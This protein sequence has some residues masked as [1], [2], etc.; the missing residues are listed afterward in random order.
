MF[1][2]GSA[3]RYLLVGERYISDPV[4][5]FITEIAFTP[6]PNKSLHAQ[7]PYQL[8]EPTKDISEIKFA[9]TCQEGRQAFASARIAYFE[10]ES[11]TFLEAAL[12]D[13]GATVSA[14][15]GWR[16]AP[17]SESD[18][19]NVRFGLRFQTPHTIEAALGECFKL[20]SFLSLISHQCVYPSNFHVRGTG[21]NEFYELHAKSARRGTEREHTWSGHTLVLPDED[22]AKF[23]EAL[24]NW[25]RD[26]DKL[27]RSRYLYRYSLEEPYIFST[28][29][30][31]CIFQAIEGIVRLS[32]GAFLP[33]DDLAKV[34]AAIRQALPGHAKLD[35]IVRKIRSN[36]TE[37]PA[38]L[39]K[40][41]LPKLFERAHVSAKFM[42]GEFVD[43]IYKRRNK[44]SH[45]GSHLPATPFDDTLVADT[46]LLTAIYLIL[47]SLR[48]GLNPNVA[49]VM[50]RDSFRVELPLE[51]QP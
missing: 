5:A 51:V 50:F 13:L 10:R 31:L 1:S 3:L 49:L 8:I 21:E 43:R 17:P 30:F 46:L 26:N 22:P 23:H 48:L 27:L 18:R 34:E 2:A 42:I 25:Y 37:S 45:G 20:C 36:N 28:D 11:E 32:G 24:Q 7:R 12:E 35:A 4:G 47:E 14:W 39:L 29:R 33:E 40:R 38:P 6:D 9:S 15:F 19:E 44:S 41:E 16:S